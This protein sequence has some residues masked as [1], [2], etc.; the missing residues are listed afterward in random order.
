MERFSRVG[1]ESTC[2]AEEREI[3]K[4]LKPYGKDNRGET[5]EGI[6]SSDCFGVWKGKGQLKPESRVGRRVNQVEC[7]RSVRRLLIGP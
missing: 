3:L 2:N 1:F 7:D 4:R 5:G 6:G